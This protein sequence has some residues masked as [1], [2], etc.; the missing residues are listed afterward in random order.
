MERT[1]LVRA[2]SEHERLAFVNN[3]HS[4]IAKLLGQSEL[5]TRCL[6]TL[7]AFNESQVLTFSVFISLSSC[8]AHTDNNRRTFKYS[9]LTGAVYEGQW[10]WG[11]V[12]LS[13][14]TLAGD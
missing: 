8:L 1:F 13:P 11:K 9:F 5:G 4:K 3:A 6:L 12:R 2:N 14:R 10:M 7:C